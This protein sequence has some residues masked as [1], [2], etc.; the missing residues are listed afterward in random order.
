MKKKYLS[1]TGALL[2]ALMLGAGAC[3]GDDD[4]QDAEGTASAL[5]EFT[6]DFNGAE[7][8]TQAAGDVKDSLNDNCDDL[9]NDVDSDE[10]DGFCE[11]LRDAIDDDDQQAFTELKGA[12]PAIE[13]QIRAK[14]AED[15]QDAAADDNDEDNPLEGGDPGDDDDTNTD[16]EG[17]GLNEDDVEN[18]TDNE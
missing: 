7:D 16:T 9:R 12:F 2:A 11:A 1:I 14:I 17:D 5:E 13:Q 10:L 6:N 4:A 3:G 8:I 18:P 15:I